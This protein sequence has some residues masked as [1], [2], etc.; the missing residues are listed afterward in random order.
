[1]DFVR[2][3]RHVAARRGDLMIARLWVAAALLACAIQ[4]ALSAQ[5]AD[6]SSRARLIRFDRFLNEEVARYRQ[7][8]AILAPAVRRPGY[9]E[10]DLLDPNAPQSTHVLER[11]A[12]YRRLLA[13]ASSAAAPP[14]LTRPAGSTTPEDHGPG[15]ADG[16]IDATGAIERALAAGDV[17]LTPGA[18][19]RLTRTLVVPAHRRLMSDGTATLR[20][21][22]AGVGFPVLPFDPRHPYAGYRDVIQVHGV[23]NVELRDFRVQTEEGIGTADQP[24]LHGVDV[25]DARHVVVTGLALEGFART[26]GVLRVNSSSDVV[27]S[28]NLLHGSYTRALTRQ[29]TGIEIDEARSRDGK[30]GPARSSDQ[31]LVGGNLIFGLLFDRALL[32]DTTLRSDHAPLNEETTGI[33][34]AAT[35]PAPTV[36]VDDNVIA[37][38]GQGIDVFSDGSRF[39]RNVIERAPEFALKV[40]HGAS[41][42]LFDGFRITA[43]GI[44]AVVLYGSPDEPVSGNRVTNFVI[45]YPGAVASLPRPF[46]YALLVETQPGHAG[47][48]RAAASDS[49]NSFAHVRITGAPA[50]GAGDWKSLIGCGWPRDTRPGDA[51]PNVFDDVRP[52]TPPLDV[53]GGCAIF[54]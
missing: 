22:T 37:D 51:R 16:V 21:A 46:S 12:S 6:G 3:G 13:N 24:L 10:A 11:Y 25:R 4:P 27:L 38:V 34:L 41:G 35:G 54:P 9:P 33:A 26:R 14:I 31:V 30:D 2:H 19:Y 8:G 39:A 29:V 28:Q 32:W 50:A 43:S 15:V 40:G 44:A 52:L 42:N 18:V 5:S 47:A 53:T 1:M 7:A 20:I 49:G 23:E 17:W 48:R 36:E 45:Q